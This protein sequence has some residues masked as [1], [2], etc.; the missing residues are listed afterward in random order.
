MGFVAYL[1][2]GLTVIVEDML[3]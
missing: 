1:E 2:E 3:G